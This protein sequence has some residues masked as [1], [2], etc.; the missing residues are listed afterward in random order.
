MRIY[1][2]PCVFSRCFKVLVE[3]LLWFNGITYTEHGLQVL[4]NPFTMRR[5]E[6]R[7][8]VLEYP[9]Q[10]A[11]LPL[12]EPLQAVDPAVVVAGPVLVPVAAASVPP[13]AAFQP[14]LPGPPRLHGPLEY[15]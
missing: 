5:I 11:H 8:I 15:R 7:A 14:P 3:H 13:A 6:C 9:I 2:A 10:L 4:Q 12:Q 1:W